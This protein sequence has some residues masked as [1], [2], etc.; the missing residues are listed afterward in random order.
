MLRLGTTGQVPI[1]KFGPHTTQVEFEVPPGVRSRVLQAAARCGL[2][3]AKTNYYKKV[4]VDSLG[5]AAVTSF[6]G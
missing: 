5:K 4:D 2:Y 6:Q 1:Q 3:G